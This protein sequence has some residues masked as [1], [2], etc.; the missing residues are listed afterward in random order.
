MNL[1][2]YPPRLYLCLSLACPSPAPSLLKLRSETPILSSPV[3]RFILFPPTHCLPVFSNW[4]RTRAL[5]NVIS[6]SFLADWTTEQ[7]LAITAH[8]IH[9][10]LSALILW[11]NESHS[12]CKLNK[13][14]HVECHSGQFYPISS[15]RGER[16]CY[17]DT[18]FITSKCWYA[19]LKAGQN[20][21]I[22]LSSEQAPFIDKTLPS[23]PGW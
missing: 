10:K 8:K 4:R 12:L 13:E 7:Q 11:S 15:C 9:I 3:S 19:W 18:S 5:Q 6:K 1:E 2:N 22:P 20:G 21:T 23:M 16:G 17:V 14:L